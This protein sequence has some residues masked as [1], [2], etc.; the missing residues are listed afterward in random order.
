M[1]RSGTSNLAAAI[2]A[3]RRALL[4]KRPH[5]VLAMLGLERLD[6]RRERMM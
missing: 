5:V 4:A 2:S 1:P 3:Y 6:Q